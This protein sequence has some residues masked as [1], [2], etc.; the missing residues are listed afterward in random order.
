MSDAERKARQRAGYQN[1]Y[2][3]VHLPSFAQALLAAGLINDAQLEDVAAIRGAA[4]R[5]LQDWCGGGA[6]V[7]R[8][9]TAKGRPPVATYRPKPPPKPKHGPVRS[10]E[11]SDTGW[12]GVSDTGRWA[13]IRGSRW[14]LNHPWT[15]THTKPAKKKRVQKAVDLRLWKTDGQPITRFIPKRQK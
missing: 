14:C 15:H 1:I 2:V 12:Q 13:V 4:A 5:A 9:L 11:G 8:D 6:R 3:E 7:L 10:W